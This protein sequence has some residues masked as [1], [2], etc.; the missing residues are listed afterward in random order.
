MTRL[1]SRA[2]LITHDGV[3]DGDVRRIADDGGVAPA[4]YVSRAF[5]VFE[6]VEVAEPVGGALIGAGGEAE[7]WRAGDAVEEGVSDG[8]VHRGGVRALQLG[9]AADFERGEHQAEAR[10]GDGVLVQ[11]GASDGVQRAARGLAGLDAWLFVP[12][13]IFALWLVSRSGLSR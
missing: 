6:G 12:P 13:R 10:D 2:H 3:F 9:V 7:L 11:V 1:V 5:F 8:E 4:E